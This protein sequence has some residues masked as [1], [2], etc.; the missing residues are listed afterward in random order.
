MN[1]IYDRTAED[2]AETKR[3]TE[4]LIMGI[5]L[6]EAEQTSYDT[7][8]RG[9]YNE[10]DM[11]RVETAVIELSAAL[12]AAGYANITV[13][14]TW[15][16]GEVV[17]AAIWAQYLANVQ[18]LINAYYTL[19]GAPAL[20]AAAERLTYIGANAIERLLAD[21]YVLIDWMQRSYRKSGTFKSGSN[22]AHLP[23]QRSVT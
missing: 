16:P 23:L 15:V 3:I 5:S 19:P 21:I 12:N 20:P 7:G 17:T 9:S 13:P 18:A 22:A 6:T 1:L 8:L 14:H 2:V 4:K 10:A 11:N